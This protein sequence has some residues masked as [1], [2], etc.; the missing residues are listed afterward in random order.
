M[1]SKDGETPEDVTARMAS[2]LREWLK[3]T[4]STDESLSLHAR[5]LLSRCET[6]RSDFGPIEASGLR[7]GPASDIA[8]VELGYDFALWRAQAFVETD[9]D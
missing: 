1:V 7:K 5:R 8:W 4:E 3:T 2:E 9:N 6:I